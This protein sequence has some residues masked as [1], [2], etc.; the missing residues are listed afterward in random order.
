M[1]SNSQTALLFSSGFTLVHRRPS[2]LAP[3]ASGHSA[4]WLYARLGDAQS[5]TPR[6]ESMD[7]F[8]KR[9]LAHLGLAEK[10]ARF[11]HLKPFKILIASLSGRSPSSAPTRRISEARCLHR[12]EQN[13]RG[14]I[15]SPVCGKRLS[16]NGLSH[17]CGDTRSLP[18]STACTLDRINDLPCMM[19]VNLCPTPA[20]SL[21]RCVC[22]PGRP[23]RF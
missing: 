17:T 6:F 9:V 20:R 1:P 22:I 3:A 7:S 19:T 11:A 14:S 5:Q 8:P 23:V 15:L 4:A 10:V 16:H 18:L 13:R 12:S 21:K 2:K